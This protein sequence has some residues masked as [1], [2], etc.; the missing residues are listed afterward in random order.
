MAWKRTERSHSPD[1]K[2]NHVNKRAKMERDERCHGTERSVVTPAE[3]QRDERPGSRVWL[4]KRSSTPSKVNA[5]L[6]PR[7]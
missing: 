1:R 5:D 6:F 2:T 4:G 7:E 3:G